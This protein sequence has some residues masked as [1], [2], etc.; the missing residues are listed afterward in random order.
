MSILSAHTACRVLAYIDNFVNFISIYILTTSVTS[1]NILEK[2]KPDKP[3][4]SSRTI[5]WIDTLVVYTRDA[6]WASNV[7]T[8]F[9]YSF[10]PAYG[11]IFHIPVFCI[12][13]YSSI[14]LKI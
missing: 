7:C 6:R 8:I 9:L 14:F 3:T 2:L 11:V 10:H 13:C 4:I 12:M 1:E 5:G